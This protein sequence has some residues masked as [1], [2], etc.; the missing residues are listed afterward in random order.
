MYRAIIIILLFAGEMFAQTKETGASGASSGQRGAL[1]IT[2]LLTNETPSLAAG[3]TD[4]KSAENTPRIWSY[5]PLPRMEDR[6]F[7]SSG[8]VG[9]IYGVMA[10]AGPIKEFIYKYSSYDTGRDQYSH[11]AIHIRPNIRR[12]SVW[13]SVQLRY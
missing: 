9:F 8:A 11:P 5:A 3:M 4:D 6:A 7:Q 13:V 12:G 1:P 2:S 10:A